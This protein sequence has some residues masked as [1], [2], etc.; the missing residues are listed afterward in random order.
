MMKLWIGLIWLCSSTLFAQD[1]YSPTGK[2]KE[3]L[4]RFPIS[5]AVDDGVMTYKLPKELTGTDE[6][7]IRLV[8]VTDNSGIRTFAGPKAT[9][10]CMGDGS[11]PGCVV[12]HRDLQTDFEAARVAINNRFA[13]N[14]LQLA[15]QSI[16]R[17]FIGNGDGSLEPIGFIGALKKRQQEW[18]IP[19]GKW[20]TYFVDDTKEDRAALEITFNETGVEKTPPQLKILEE[21]VGELVEV[22]WTA[23][24]AAGTWVIK[25]S[26]R[27]FDFT[28]NEQLNKF[29]GYYGIYEMKEDGKEVATDEATKAPKTIRLGRW[30][31]SRS[32]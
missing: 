25:G 29:E 12:K 20:L 4:A 26:K 5:V 6:N 24:H 1:Y 13:D 11:K 28:F 18:V 2:D 7:S 19:A 27:W 16:S 15:A 10:V 3:P 30:Y 14:Q 8:Q 23:F 32:N 22:R 31:G 21:T 17:E 9:A